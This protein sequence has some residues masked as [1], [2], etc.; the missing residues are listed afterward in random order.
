MDQH[1]SSGIYLFRDYLVNEVKQLNLLANF[2]RRILVYLSL[3]TK[4]SV[5]ARPCLRPYQ[6]ESKYRDGHQTAKI[7]PTWPKIESFLKT[8]LT[9]VY[10]T[11]DVWHSLSDHYS[12]KWSETTNLN[13]FDRQRAK[14]GPMSPKNVIIYEDST[15]QCIHWNWC[16]LSA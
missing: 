7:K 9:S 2:C 3:I 15:N 11:D 13:H 8:P 6:R 4:A 14:I 1:S 16:G 10:T 12:W 5:V